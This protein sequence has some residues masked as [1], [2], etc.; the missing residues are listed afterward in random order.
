M[1]G[2]IRSRL[3][4]LLVLAVVGMAIGGIGTTVVGAGSGPSDGADARFVVSERNV[5][6]STAHEDV[7][8]DKDMSNVTSVR[9]E[10][11]GSGRFSVDT[12]REVSLTDADRERAKAIVRDNET[13]RRYLD[14]EDYE[15]GVDTIKRVDTTQMQVEKNVSETDKSENSSM[16]EFELKNETREGSD[17]SVVVDREPSNVTDE[18]VVRVRDPSEDDRTDLKYSVHVDLVNKT[19]T[20]FTDWDEIRRSERTVDGT[21]IENTTADLSE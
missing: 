15:L 18:A 11:T 1:P 14:D 17:G 4:V 9:I 8:I 16:V 2:D 13:V 21:E 12:E 20:D 19:V 6:F 5:T 3:A 7:R 10:E